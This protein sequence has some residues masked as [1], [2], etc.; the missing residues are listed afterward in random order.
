[1]ADDTAVPLLGHRELVLV[2]ERFKKFNPNPLPELYAPNPYCFLLSVVL[3]AQATDKS[4]NAATAPLY[5]IVRSPEQM[6]ELGRER[7]ISYIR[8]IGLY[9]SKADH[10]MA[11]SRK[12]IEDFNGT[13]PDTREG[14]M[15]LPGVGRKTAN[16]IL[17]VVFHQPTMPV[18]THLLRIC[19]KIGI[20]AGTTPLEVEKSLL[21][22]VPQE[23]LL[24]AHH[25]LLLHGRY[26]CTARR[27][28]CETCVISEFCLYQRQFQ[29]SRR[30]FETVPNLPQEPQ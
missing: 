6:L 30:T 13:V 25:W 15:T 27:P 17:N 18:D 5:E 24:H 21:E 7:L 10:I 14:L 8:S 26:V 9:N 23:Y 2:F 19:P 12:L 29:K 11:L 16:V 20:A 4:V 3:S 1:M 28:S 22:R